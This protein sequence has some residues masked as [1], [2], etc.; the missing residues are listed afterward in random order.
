M[1]AGVQGFGRNRR[2]ITGGQVFSAGRP[3]DK[4]RV[5]GFVGFGLDVDF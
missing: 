5:S 2:S 3:F 4:L 1:A